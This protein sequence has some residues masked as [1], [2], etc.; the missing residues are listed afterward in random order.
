[1]SDPNWSNVV[2]LSGFEG[3]SVT[4]ESALAQTVT[5]TGTTA[6][7]IAWAAYGSKSLSRPGQGTGWASVPHNAAMV[8]GSSPFTIEGIFRWTDFGVRWAVRST[9]VMH[10]NANGVSPLSF[11][12]AMR[13]ISPTDHRLEL[14]IDIDNDGY[15][16]Y[17]LTSNT[18]VLT[19][20]TDY[21]LAVDFDGTYYRFYVN[22]TNVKT[23]TAAYTLSTP[24]APMFIGANVS[25]GAEAGSYYNEFNG[26]IDEVRVTVGTARYATD[27]SFPA[28][29]GP[30]P[31]PS[32]RRRLAP[33]I[34]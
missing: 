23:I 7:S 24:T 27:T 13:Y 12:F 19:V 2:F 32:T 34:N 8:I 5:L 1:M 22:G 21:H 26:Y 28:L 30:F 33:V 17:A 29:T 31:R 10:G 14:E 3:G 9:L 18:F 16:D 20:D 25:A 11:L 6:Q 4:D 15:V